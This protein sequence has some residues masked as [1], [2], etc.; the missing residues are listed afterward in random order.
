MAKMEKRFLDDGTA[1]SALRRALV[2][3][4]NLPFVSFWPNGKASTQITTSYPSGDMQAEERKS[5]ERWF[6]YVLHVSNQ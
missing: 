2:L 4:H 3:N 6:D 1:L 5:L